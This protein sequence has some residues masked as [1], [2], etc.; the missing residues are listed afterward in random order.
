MKTK[1]A[2]SDLKAAIEHTQANISCLLCYERKPEECHR[3]IV[4][5][6]IAED[7]GQQIVHIGIPSGFAKQKKF[8]PVY[9]EFVYA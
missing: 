8:K 1:R 7:T 3:T 6:A 5:K 2:Q 4:A 9:P